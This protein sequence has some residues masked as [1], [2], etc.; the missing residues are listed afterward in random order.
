MHY[1]YHSL[2]PLSI[3]IVCDGNLFTTPL[4]L[5]KRVRVYSS[6]SRIPVVP[7]SLAESRLTI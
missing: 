1:T 2:I 7:T 3:E 6:Q 4:R 5:L